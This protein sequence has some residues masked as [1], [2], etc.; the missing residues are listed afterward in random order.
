MAASPNLPDQFSSQPIA[1]PI[2]HEQLVVDKERVETGRVRIVKQVR[3]E[4]QTVEVPVTQ[5][6]V[7]IER[8]ALHR[9]I[10]TVPSVRHEGD[11]LVIPVVREELVVEKRLVLVEEIRITRKSTETIHS[12]DVTLRREELVIDR[13]SSGP[14]VPR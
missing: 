6:D 4:V 10:E 3:E 12:Q 8:V 2:V 11:T 14:D 7:D 5:E 1:V 13:Q 9:P